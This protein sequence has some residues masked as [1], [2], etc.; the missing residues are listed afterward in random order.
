[1]YVVIWYHNEDEQTFNAHLS[2]VSRSIV[3]R[4]CV[5]AH[6]R[7]LRIRASF[8]RSDPRPNTNHILVNRTTA[9]RMV[10]ACVRLMSFLDPIE[11]FTT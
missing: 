4:S 9:M 1:M 6:I 7:F 2:R 10:T 11:H 8:T 5:K 3:R